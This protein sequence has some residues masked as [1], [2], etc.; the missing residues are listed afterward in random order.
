MRV[1]LV[2]LRHGTMKFSLVQAFT[3]GIKELE[4]GEASLRRLKLT[5]DLVSH[6]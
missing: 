4:K 3:P 2:R 1:V 6:P 5:K